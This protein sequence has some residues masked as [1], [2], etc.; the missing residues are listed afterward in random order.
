MIFVTGDTHG[1]YKRLRRFFKGK[2]VSPQNDILV[3]LGDTGLNYYG[4][5]RDLPHKRS[6][7]RVPLTLFCVRGNHDRRPETLPDLHSVRRFGGKAYQEKDFPN[8]LYASDGEIYILESKTVLV[9][10]GAYSIDKDWRLSH[11]YNWFADEQ[12]TPEEKH[13]IEN[14]LQQLGWTV[15]T[16]LTH[17]CP[18]RF[19]PVEAFFASVDQSGVDK[20]M[21]RWLDSLE[22]RLCYRQW[23]CGHFHIDKSCG[24][25]RFL[26]NDVAILQVNVPRDAVKNIE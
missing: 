23:F 24:A 6:A 21:E 5:E 11:G 14:R 9:I 2:D 20:S 8:I 22:R 19:E 7:A 25:F 1:S 4:N 15:D 3:I 10:G 26:F 16:V 13:Q 18:L 17:T 12:T